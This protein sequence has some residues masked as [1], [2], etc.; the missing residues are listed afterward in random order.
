MGFDKFHSLDLSLIA[1][2]IGML[3]RP[4]GI[5]LDSCS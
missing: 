5:E 3:K 4:S 1:D 2:E